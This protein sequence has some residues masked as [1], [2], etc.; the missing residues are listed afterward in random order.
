[1]MM[2]IPPGFQ[3][4]QIYFE[5]YLLRNTLSHLNN[6]IS[7]NMQLLCE[8]RILTNIGRYMVHMTDSVYEGLIIPLKGR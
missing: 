5:S 4:H 2:Q 3:E 7:L 6:T 8:P 1:M